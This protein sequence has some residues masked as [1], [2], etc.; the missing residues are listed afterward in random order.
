[1][2]ERVNDRERIAVLEAQAKDTREEVAGI[3]RRIHDLAN[4]MTAVEYLVHEVKR[5][6]GNIET[7][8]NALP[9]IIRDNSRSVAEEVMQQ[10]MEKREE[11]ERKRWT[12]RLGWMGFGAALI[13]IILG[14]VEHFT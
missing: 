2:A 9:G 10:G 13:T 11:I 1:M 3:R 8:Q 6:A 7:L 4:R 12:L 14:I 5:L